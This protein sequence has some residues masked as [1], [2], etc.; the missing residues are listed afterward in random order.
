[1]WFRHGRAT[2]A[3]L[4][5]EQL[6]A[7]SKPADDEDDDGGASPEEEEAAGAEATGAEE[8]PSATERRLCG[9]GFPWRSGFNLRQLSA[10]DARFE[11]EQQLKPM[12][13]AAAALI[14]GA[15]AR[16]AAEQYGADYFTLADVAEVL[17]AADTTAGFAKSWAALRGDAAAA[18]ARA[19][20]GEHAAVPAWRRLAG[21]QTALE[22]TLLT[23]G[24]ELRKAAVMNCP[25]GALSRHALP[26]SG[27]DAS[28][29]LQASS[30]RP[31]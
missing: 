23:F 11:V 1:V 28:L 22:E 9:G 27:S 26:A 14:A 30:K 5:R 13:L 24:A 17:V 21:R 19:A 6:A 16:L 18:A 2:R 29:V 7:A 12:A 4:E 3:R 8:A 15:D 10:S 31:T 25:H 20:V